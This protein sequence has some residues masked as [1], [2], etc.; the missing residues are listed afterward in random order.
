MHGEAGRFFRAAAAAL[1]VVKLNLSLNDY[2]F[3]WS[4]PEIVADEE[5]LFRENGVDVRWEDVTPRVLT[6]KTSLYTNLLRERKTDVYHAGEWACISRVT[7]SD[8]AWIVA[9]SKPG[10]GTLNSSFSIYVR[11]DSG[12]KSPRDL[13]GKPVA[14]EAGT[15]SYYTAMQD[16][17]R[18]LPRKSVKL[19]ELGEPHKRLI[20]LMEGEVAAAS[21]VGP[22]PAIGEVFGLERLVRTTR[23]NPTTMVTRKDFDQELLAR[24]LKATNRAIRMIDSEPDRFSASYFKRVERILKSM[25]H[26]FGSHRELIRKSVRVSAW[27]PW[28]RYTSGDFRRTSRWMI[29]RG[30]LDARVDPATVVAEYPASMY[31]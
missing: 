18:F 17:E 2:A 23:K 25:S 30:L 19:V 29:S 7:K 22:W 28:E 9:A 4:F 14:I 11:R 10:R 12:L 21:L 20:S 16:L 8:D 5:G 1:K 24:F 15:G 6:N 27:K 13:A 26:E 31:A 3:H